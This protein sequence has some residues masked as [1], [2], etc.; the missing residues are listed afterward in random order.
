[1]YG[2]LARLADDRFWKMPERSRL[3]FRS[4]RNEAIPGPGAVAAFQRILAT[5]RDHGPESAQ[6]GNWAY[7]Y[8]PM[9]LH[10]RGDWMVAV[11]GYSKYLWAFERSVVDARKDARLENVFGFNDSACAIRVYGTGAP[12][13]AAASGYSKAGWDWSR[14]PG[15]TTRLIPP[16]KLEQLDIL[17]AKFNRPYA[18][19]PFCGA[20]SHDGHGVF[21]QA[22]NEVGFDQENT[23]PGF[24]SARDPRE[25]PKR[26]LLRAEKS[27]F[28]FGDQVFCLTSGVRN[29][30]GVHPVGTTLFQSAADEDHA[31]RLGPNTLRDSAGNGYF[32]PRPKALMVRNTVQTAPG[33]N[34]TPPVSGRFA[35][36]WFDHGLSP[37]DDSCTFVILPQASETEIAEFADSAAETF[38]VLQ[39]DDHAHVVKHHRLGMTGVAV[40]A[41][42]DVQRGPLLNADRPLLLMVEERG[43][44]LLVSVCDPDLRWQPGV[45]YRHKKDES[46]KAPKTEPV[47]VTIQMT[48]RGQWRAD[49]AGVT[50]TVQTGH[51]RVTVRA[52]AGEAVT[53]ELVGGER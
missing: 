16:E 27:V 42:G 28:F 53:F 48:L 23:T 32:V 49:T 37:T 24:S 18:I 46:G 39:Q 29:G 3:V 35:T 12:V 14:I 36:A 51:T 31:T 38:A 43:Q 33:R 9:S 41:A 6:S 7:N 40:F 50:T 52:D 15:A 45:H 19:S 4:A 26:P 20:L 11:K 22:Y 8:G 13:S 10:R 44:K 25:K 21:A 1:M 5:A 2:V 30:D 47:A 34:A 17:G